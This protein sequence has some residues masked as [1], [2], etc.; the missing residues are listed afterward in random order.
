MKQIFK[1]LITYGSDSLRLTAGYNIILQRYIY[2]KNIE[3][4]QGII[5]PEISF[6]WDLNRINT[7]NVFYNSNSEVTPYVNAINHYYF[8]SYNSITRG[9]STS[10][11]DKHHL[12]AIH[13]LGK[14]NTRFFM[15]CKLLYTYEPRFITNYTEPTF[16]YSVSSD[17]LARN[18]NILIAA[19]ETNYFILAMRSNVKL[20]FSNAALEYSNYIFGIS[21]RNK[22]RSSNTTLE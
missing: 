11:F 14:F 10:F 6:K 18:R 4:T 16:N 1:S 21:N 5:L 17:T 20:L 3:I 9:L 15:N 2:N 22:S 12:G 7:L 8:T 19:I 13:S